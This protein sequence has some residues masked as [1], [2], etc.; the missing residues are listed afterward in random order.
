MTPTPDLARLREAVDAATGPGD[1]R[2]AVAKACEAL[3]GECW[4]TALS[5]A[6]VEPGWFHSGAYIEFVVGAIGVA[7]PRCNCWGYDRTPKSTT[8]YVSRNCVPADD[9]DRWLYEADGPTPALALLRALIA[10]IT[11]QETAR[12]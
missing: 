5:D 12:G 8:A 6:R 11:T 3:F 1:E 9:K 2:S 10:A 7:L 4:M